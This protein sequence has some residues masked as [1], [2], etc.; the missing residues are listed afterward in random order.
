MACSVFYYHLKR[1]KDKEKYADEMENLISIFREHKECYVYRR[2]TSE[3]RNR[4][5]VINHKTV[6]RLMQ[7]MGIKNQIYK[8]RYCSYK[9]EIGR[10]ASSIIN[11]NFVVSAHNQK[12]ETDVT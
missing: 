5:F 3:M 4:N 1:L 10:M 7:V 9:G 8:V 12:W 6:L 2:I 11:R